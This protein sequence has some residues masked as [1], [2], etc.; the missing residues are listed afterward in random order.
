MSAGRLV[1]IKELNSKKVLRAPT[2]LKIQQKE[3]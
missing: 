3:I 2:E 1:F